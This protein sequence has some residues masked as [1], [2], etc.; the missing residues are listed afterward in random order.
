MNG[1][2]DHIRASVA[3]AVSTGSLS[4]D[5][6]Q[7]IVNLLPAPAA[8]ATTVP[9]AIDMVATGR[10]V[11]PAPQPD[12]VKIPPTLR[13]RLSVS[14]TADV[15]TVA[16]SIRAKNNGS[17]LPAEVMWKMGFTCE[18]LYNFGYRKCDVRLTQ[19]LLL[20]EARCTEPFAVGELTV[21]FQFSREDILCSLG[22]RATTKPMPRASM[23]LLLGLF[24]TNQNAQSYAAA[25]FDVP[26]LHYLGMDIQ[27]LLHFPF[28]VKDMAAH[29]GLTYD[30]A[31][32]M[33]LTNDVC[34]T[35]G[36]GYNDVRTALRMTPAQLT[37]T[38][39][40]LGNLLVVPQR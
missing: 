23:Q 31:V 6:G 30:L 29:M 27:T 13:L 16:S 40:D 2:I 28:G 33:G 39:F 10:I 25:G 21:Y 36:W 26:F 5:V 32:A 18:D 14:L 3:A 37:K 4:E 38:G 17:L 8:V 20:G 19:A 22:V 11:V 7:A 34:K 35:V 9:V 24:K 1:S 15:A 12:L